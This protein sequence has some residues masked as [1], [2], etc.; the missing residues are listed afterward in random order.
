MNKNS[1]AR[2]AATAAAALAVATSV[3]LGTPLAASAHVHID[4]G[5]AAP[6][7]Y[8]TVTFKVPTESAT[9]STISLT[10]DLPT[11]TPFTSV[12]YQPVPGW[13]TRVITATLSAPVV[14]GDATVTEAPVSVVWTA[15]PGSGIAPGQFQEFPLS[16][17][18]VP[19]TG[20]VALAAH[21]G[22]SDGTTVDWS[23]ATP[24][25]GDEPEHPAPI[26]YITDAPPAGDET[27]AATTDAAAGAGA[28]GSTDAG[29]SADGLTASTDGVAAAA[30]AAADAG[31]ASAALGLGLGG[32]VLGTL[33]LVVA[34]VALLRRPAAGRI[35]GSK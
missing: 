18:P 4:P 28:D 32:L 30:D 7:T 16:L 27:S 12:S 6:G 2:A 10:V 33:A 13:T 29:S 3:A 34:A 8:P 1:F 31:V 20:Q 11:D 26:L 24:A 21:Q 19:D 17:G 15:D 35:A 23:D 9:A 25:S 22:Y 14:S 5:Q